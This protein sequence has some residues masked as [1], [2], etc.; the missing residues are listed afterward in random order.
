MTRIPLILIAVVGALPGCGRDDARSIPAQ[1]DVAARPDLSQATQHDLAAEVADAERRGTWREVR[2][3]WEGQR[4]TWK[5]MRH[6]ALCGD[7]TACNIAPF[8]IQRPAQNGWLP[9]LSFAPGEFTKLD[10]A[11]GKRETCELEFS[12]TLSRLELSGELPTAVYFKDVRVVK[13]G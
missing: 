5:V 7:E 8:P 12:G 13:A 10:A 2:R 4:L 9:A 6:Q 11:C 1:R 3:R